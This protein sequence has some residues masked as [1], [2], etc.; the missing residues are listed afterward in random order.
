M[1][2]IALET[3]RT[4]SCSRPLSTSGLCEHWGNR[5]NPDLF[6]VLHLDPKIDGFN[7]NIINDLLLFLRRYYHKFVHWN[8]DIKN[9]KELLNIFGQIYPGK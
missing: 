7:F 1:S 2:N 3:G 5:G 8:R 6:N 4:N 9:I